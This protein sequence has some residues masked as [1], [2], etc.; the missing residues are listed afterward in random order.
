MIGVDTRALGLGSLHAGGESTSG[1]GLGIAMDDA[2]SG[3]PNITGLDGEG[4]GIGLAAAGIGDFVG[5]RGS[6]GGGRRPLNFG[7]RQR[8]TVGGAWSG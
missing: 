4:L 6:G 3:L 5:D 8:T 1:L 7:G 2:D